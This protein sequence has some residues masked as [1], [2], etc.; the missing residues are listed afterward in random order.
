MSQADRPEFFS[1]SESAIKLEYSGAAS[2]GSPGRAHLRDR[3]QG[4]SELIWEGL[5]QAEWLGHRSGVKPT[6]EVCFR[7]RR[8]DPSGRVS[9]REVELRPGGP[10]R[11]RTIGRLGDDGTVYS[12]YVGPLNA[13]AVPGMLL[14]ESE[15]RPEDF[16]YL[17]D[18]LFS[19]AIEAGWLPRDPQD[20]VAAEVSDV[21]ILVG[22]SRRD[23]AN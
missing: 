19:A 23:L 15:R 5:A 16:D 2:V 21:T 8:A 7:V 11:Q 4:I 1:V 12:M 9:S 10:R 14:T 20:R 18:M 3:H 6:I 17:E 22:V 13:R